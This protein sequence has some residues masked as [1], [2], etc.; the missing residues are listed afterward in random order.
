MD[1]YKKHG[2]NPMGGCFP[3]LIQIPFF[4]RVLQGVRGF[5]GNARRQLAVGDAIFRS[6]STWPSASCRSS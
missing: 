4:Y 6:R 3:M 5:G 1:L 2:V